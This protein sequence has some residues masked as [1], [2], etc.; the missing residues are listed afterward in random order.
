MLD[1][2][3]DGLETNNI[4]VWIEILNDSIAWSPRIRRFR[5]FDGW[6]SAGNVSRGCLGRT[7]HA[8]VAGLNG[9]VSVDPAPNLRVVFN[10]VLIGGRS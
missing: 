10:G 3:H 7:H 4:E 1:R 8:D 2:L 5:S 9:R 6:V